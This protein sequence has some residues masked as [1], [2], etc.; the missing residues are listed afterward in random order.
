MSVVGRSEECRST[1]PWPAVAEGAWSPQEVA[2][3]PVAAPGTKVRAQTPSAQ[4][5]QAQRT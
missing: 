2:L 5:A 4:E 1:R 3:R